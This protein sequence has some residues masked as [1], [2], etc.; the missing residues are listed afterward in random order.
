M[1]NNGAKDDK[2][3]NIEL[4]G[5]EF[6]RVKN[7]LDEAQ[8]TSFI[9][10]IVNQR[11]TLVQRDEHLLSLTKL[12]EKV[13]SE[14]DNL[15]EEIKTEAIEQGKAEA[16]TIIVKAEEQSQ[17]MIEEKR[18]EIVTIA[19]E[20]A[21]AI[22][23]NAEREVELLL[24]KRK[25]PI[26]DELINFVHQ[27]C[28]QLVSELDSLKQ[29]AV[30]LGAAFE[31]KLS[32]VT[33]ETSAVTMEADDIHAQSQELI[34][35]IN[36]IVTSEPEEKA[37]VSADDADTVP[38]EREPEFE[39]EIIPPVDIIKIMRIVNYLDSLP[40]VENTELIPLTDSPSILVFLREPIGLIDMLGTLPE[41]AEVKEDATNTAGT[42]GEQKKVQILLSEKAV[43]G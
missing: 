23:A 10:E 29:Q 4:G 27:L 31:D 14:A 20:Q 21:A 9:N 16:A 38:Y 19:N 24:E 36:Q 15:A 8:V 6:K 41:V 40:E 22:K 32:Q 43:L 11:D 26:Q 34:Q 18:T 7:G 13:V 35:T 1:G 37:S 12:A 39:V 3:N 28:G 42:E 5:C 25:K 30:A 2:H 33:E 17:R